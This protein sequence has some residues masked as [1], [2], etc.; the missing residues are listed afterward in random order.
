M[1]IQNIADTVN[2]TGLDHLIKQIDG[3]EPGKQQR[4]NLLFQKLYPAVERAIARD[5]PHKSI[6]SQLGTMG[7]QLSMGGFRS[8]L[9]SE[10][11]LR[12]ENGDRVC[13]ERCGSALPRDKGASDTE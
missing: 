1:E 10:R 12:N 2:S 7:L 4:K 3:L 6:I 11:K 13:C 9:E 5:V 8:L